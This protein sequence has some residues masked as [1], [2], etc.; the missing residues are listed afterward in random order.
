[1]EGAKRITN[2]MADLL[3]LI[4]KFCLPIYAGRIVSSIGTLIA[5]RGPDYY[6]VHIAYSALTVAS[7]PIG[8]SPRTMQAL[9]SV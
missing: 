1:M 9:G 3:K 6:V 5:E 7:F 8:L 4:S 2:L